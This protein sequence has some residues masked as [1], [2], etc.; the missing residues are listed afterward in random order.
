M[1]FEINSKA[2]FQ[3]GN[4]FMANAEACLAFLFRSYSLKQIKVN[5]VLCCVL[6]SAG[7]YLALAVYITNTNICMSLFEPD[8]PC[9]EHLHTSDQN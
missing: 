4:L 5:A 1:V 9:S 2:L 8:H 3:T 6:C 7:L